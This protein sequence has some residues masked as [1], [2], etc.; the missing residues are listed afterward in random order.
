MHALL[1]VLQPLH[2]SVCRSARDSFHSTTCSAFT[3][4]TSC[5]QRACEF[6]KEGK[7][8]NRERGWKRHCQKYL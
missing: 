1:P 4:V 5:K 8:S 7:S 3:H 6:G 2:T